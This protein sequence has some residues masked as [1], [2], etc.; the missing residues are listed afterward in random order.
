MGQKRAQNIDWHKYS[1]LIFEKG[2]KIQSFQQIVLE[3]LGSHMQKKQISAKPLLL[4]QKLI[5]L[6]WVTDINAKL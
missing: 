5:Y 6:K 1:Q 2:E 3:Q 4:S